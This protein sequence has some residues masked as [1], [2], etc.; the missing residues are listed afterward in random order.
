[1]VVHNV[2][3]NKPDSRSFVV[4]TDNNNNDSQPVDNLTQNR[5]MNRSENAKVAAEDKWV[6]SW[7]E[8]SKQHK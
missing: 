2:D 7:V 5:W 8:N 6:P 3:D 1:M 4:L